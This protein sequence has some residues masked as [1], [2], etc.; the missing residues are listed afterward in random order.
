MRSTISSKRL[1]DELLSKLFSVFNTKNFELILEQLDTF[2]ALLDAF[3]SDPKLKKKV[4][5]VSA[6]LKEDLLDAIK[7]L[8]PEHVFTVQQ[9]DSDRCALFLKKFLGSG[10]HIYTTNYDLLLY[11]VLMRNQVFESVDS[12]GQDKENLDEYVPEDELEYSELRWGKYRDNQVIF[13]VHGAL[14]LF[15][16]GVEIIKEEYDNGHYL[17]ENVG[18]RI[19]RGEYP[20]FVTADNGCEKLTHIMHNR[21]LTH[22]YESL[23]NMEGSLVTF[24]I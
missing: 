15:D 23:T 20:I 9:G 18:E 22:C 11:W 16:T 24:G 6:T 19:S 4:D 12:F 8:H 10:G 13:Y 17:L 7:A 5:A 3:G 14:P 2:S 1:N 21:Y